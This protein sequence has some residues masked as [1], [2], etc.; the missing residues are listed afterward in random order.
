MK[1]Y[2]VYYYNDHRFDG[3]YGVFKTD[4]AAF[5]AAEILAE[6]GFRVN[7]QMFHVKQ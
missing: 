6:K 1:I 4:K 2:V 7:I 5:D 3:I